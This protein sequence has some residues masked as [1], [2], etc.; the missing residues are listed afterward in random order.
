MEMGDK[1]MIPICYTAD[2]GYAMQVAVSMVS[3]LENNRKEELCFYILADDYSPD[4][5][6]KFK[7]IESQYDCKICIINVVEKLKMLLETEIATETGIIR[8]GNVSFMFA[9]L[10]V[11]SSL[12]ASIDKVIYIDSDTLFI[13][14]V[15]DLFNIE[16]EGDCL[17]AAVRD[18]WPAVYNRVIGLEVDDL[19][20]QSGIMLIDLKKWRKEKCEEAVLKHIS[21]MKQYYMLHDQDILNLCFHGRIQT[22]PVT[23]GMV[24]LL[25]EYNAKQILDFSGK[26]EEHYYSCEEISRAKGRIYVVHYAGDYFGRPWIYPNACPDSRLWYHYYKKTPW[27]DEFLAERYRPSYN[28]KYW[29]KKVLYPFTKRLWLKCIKKRFNVEIERML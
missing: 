26:D 23:F 24:Y 18:L 27:E 3:M 1:I 15:R 16:L 20:F 29:V 7:Y 2:E 9:R 13:D 14:N 12:P 8:N 6:K 17:Y 22:L 11:G 21:E 10:F 28:I 25:R 19:Y 5:R 4:T